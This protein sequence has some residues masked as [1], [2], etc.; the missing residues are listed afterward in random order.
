MARHEPGSSGDL[1]FATTNWKLIAAAKGEDESRATSTA[2]AVPT[3]PSPEAI[4]RLAAAMSRCC[5]ARTTERSQRRQ[6][7]PWVHYHRFLS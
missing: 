4:R 7:S 5:S 3:L 2:T 6:P 1:R